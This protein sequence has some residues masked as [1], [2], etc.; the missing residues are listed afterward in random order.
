MCILSVCAL[1]SCIHTYM[2]LCTPVLRDLLLGTCTIG[3]VFFLELFVCWMAEDAYYE[4]HCAYIQRY[5]LTFIYLRWWC[6]KQR[7]P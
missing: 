4:L 6:M 2:Y 5:V 7:V 3:V 1:L